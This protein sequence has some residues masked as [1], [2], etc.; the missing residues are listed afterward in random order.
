M[1]TVSF[2]LPPMPT[3]TPPADK[4]LKKGQLI[5]KYLKDNE[6]KVTWDRK[7]A[8][9][10]AG[11]RIITENGRLGTIV[12]GYGKFVHGWYYPNVVYDEDVDNGRMV[13]DSDTHELGLYVILNPDAPLPPFT[14]S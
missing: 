3:V 2:N 11:K 6:D 13:I 9:K 4:P 12:H 5:D 14:W 8:P 7:I 10:T 1:P